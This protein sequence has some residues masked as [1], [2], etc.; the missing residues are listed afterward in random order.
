VYKKNATSEFPKKSTLQFLSIKD[1]KPLGIEIE[2]LI[3]HITVVVL[4]NKCINLALCTRMCSD[5]D[6]CAILN[7]KAPK[8]FCPENNVDFLGNSEVAFFYKPCSVVQGVKKNATS[9]F[10]KKS[11]LQFLSIKYFRPLGIEIELL[12]DHITVV[13][14]LNKS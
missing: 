12:I 2:L 9:E 3:D 14:L 1:F 4:L 13:V 6:S 8:I 7:S 5:F 10:P 11:P